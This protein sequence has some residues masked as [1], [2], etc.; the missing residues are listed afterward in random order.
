MRDT[1]RRFCY[2]FL[3]HLILVVMLVVCS[4]MTA[5]AP[6]RGNE[7]KQA[8]GPRMWTFPKD[9]GAHPE[10]RTEW[11]YFTG[12]LVDDAGAC[13]GYQ[14]TFFRQGIQF[15]ASNSD[16]PWSIRDVYVAHFAITAVA[17]N[18]F[19]STE[20]ISR[21]GPGL[22]GAQTD[23]ID[24]WILDWF[25][26]MEDNTIFLQARDARNLSDHGQDQTVRGESG[27]ALRQQPAAGLRPP[28]R[29]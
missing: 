13:Y 24:V 3:V 19:W 26:K 12:N 15:T 16:N 6:G 9:H 17:A 28:L 4:G 1:V 27:R 10:Y 11:W 20:R 18:Q 21:P 5:P 2:E 22:A 14:L 25:A 23:A 8:I 7:W 29:R